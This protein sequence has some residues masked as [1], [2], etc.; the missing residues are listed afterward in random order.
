MMIILGKK[1][2]F[3]VTVPPPPHLLHFFTAILTGTKQLFYSGLSNVKLKKKNYCCTYFFQILGSNIHFMKI[4]KSNLT[5]GLFSEFSCK[6]RFAKV[7][8]AI[9]PCF[10]KPNLT[11]CF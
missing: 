5:I 6:S 2:N 10:W 7:D 4:P 9:T 3:L 1:L 11:F 8:F